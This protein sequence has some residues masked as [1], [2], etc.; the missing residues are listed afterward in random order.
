[1]N[2]LAEKTMGIVIESKTK[3][4]LTRQKIATK[5]SKKWLH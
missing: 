2:K 5:R 4:E 3:S 1:M